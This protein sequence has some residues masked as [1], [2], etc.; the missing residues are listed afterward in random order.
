MVRPMAH[1]AAGH[2]YSRLFATAPDLA[3]LFAGANMTSQGHRLMATLG[4][5]VRSLRDGAILDEVT[6]DLRTRHAGYRV[7][8]EHYRPFGEALVWALGQGLGPA[9]DDET[10][11][12]WVA[13]YDHLTDLMTGAT[14]QGGVHAAE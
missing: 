6:G 5:I 12:A 11:A 10:S 3:P 13:A 8:P 4:L 9:F 2:F 14:A 7:R 1:Q